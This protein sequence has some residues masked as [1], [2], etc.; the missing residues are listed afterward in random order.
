MKSEKQWPAD[1]VERRAVA[2]L[3]PAARNARTHSDEQIGQLAASI[4][5]WGWTTPVLLD[6]AGGIIAGHGRVLA[7]K[8]LKIETIPCMVARGWSEAQKRAYVIADNRLALDAGW[9]EDLLRIEFAE[10]KSLDFDIAPIGFTIAEVN[11]LINGVGMT[12]TY[13]NTAAQLSDVKY[14]ILVNC[15][16]EADQAAMLERFEQEGIKCRP[17]ML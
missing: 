11:D 14:H 5:E 10:L 2:D 17:L 1:A 12:G 13:S 9:D 6:E 3:V 8:K 7:A 15:A 4:K 16:D